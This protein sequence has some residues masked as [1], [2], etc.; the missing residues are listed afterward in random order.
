MFSI[1]D[2]TG[3]CSGSAK[4]HY[5]KSDNIHFD[6]NNNF[7][8]YPACSYLT[9]SGNFKILKKHYFMETLKRRR[10]QM[11]TQRTEV[12]FR[13]ARCPRGCQ[14]KVH[15][16]LW[17][18]GPGR[19]GHY[20]TTVARGTLLT[21]QKVRKVSGS[22]RRWRMFFLQQ[23]EVSRNDPHDPL[24]DTRDLQAAMGERKIIL[25]LLNSKISI[26]SLRT[27]AW[28]LWVFQR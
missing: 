18:C 17:S 24:R 28:S 2:S 5:L 7:S 25:C 3:W 22:Q 13:G 16:A 19:K 9:E 20:V 6:A 1:S 26:R 21:K 11:S 15:C 10:L 23:L 12:I 8:G 27:S 14:R 4:T